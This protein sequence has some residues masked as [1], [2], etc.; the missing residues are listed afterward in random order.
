MNRYYSFLVLFLLIMECKYNSHQVE[1]DYIRNLE[2]KN[3]ALER[4]LET[5]KKQFKFVSNP[6]REKHV[7]KTS[8][9]HFTLGSTE[10]EVII[11]MGDPGSYIITAPEAKRF[12]YG[13]ST[14]YFYKGKVI[15]YDN[16]EGN[17]KVKV[18]R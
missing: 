9:D 17:L 11:I 7:T 4:E 12:H 18:R 8:K 5:L 3:K 14:V 1:K 6:Q 2:E 10:A 16:L 15:S 13:L